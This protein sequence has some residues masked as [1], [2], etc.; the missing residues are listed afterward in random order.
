MAFCL[1]SEMFGSLVSVNIFSEVPLD[2]WIKF[3]VLVLPFSLFLS[4]SFGSV[5]V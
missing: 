5:G 1:F 4:V 3:G 2:H